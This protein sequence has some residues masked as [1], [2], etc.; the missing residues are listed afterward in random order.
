MAPTCPSAATSRAA[1][2][3]R[4]VEPAST[5]TWRPNPSPGPRR[6]RPQNV[7]RGEVRMSPTTTSRASLNHEAIK[8]FIGSR[9]LNAKK[10]LLSGKFAK[11]IRELL[12]QRG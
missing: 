9:V 11:E 5:N 6:D 3:A 8:P 10:D 12:E 4:M 2:V 7:D 1:S